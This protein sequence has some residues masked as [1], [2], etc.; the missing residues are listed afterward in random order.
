V[1]AK[2]KVVRPL[3]QMYFL[4]SFDWFNKNIQSNPAQVQAITHIVQGTAFPSPYIIFGPPG[5]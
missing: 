1:T 4:P 5:N 3:K 2:K